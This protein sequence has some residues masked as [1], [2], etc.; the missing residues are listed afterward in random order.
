MGSETHGW[1]TPLSTVLGAVDVSDG[2]LEERLDEL[3]CVAAQIFD[4]AGAGLMVLDADSHLRLI[5]ASDEAGQALER[6]QLEACAGPGIEA[7]RTREIVEVA[8]FSGD[9]RW[10]Q[11]QRAVTSFGIR[12]VLSAPIWLRDRAA[13]NLNLFDSRP[14]PW[15]STDRERAAAF[16]DV[17]GGM[18]LLAVRAHHQAS[19]LHRLRTRL[20]DGP[21]QPEDKP[22]VA[23]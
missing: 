13:G 3:V 9:N 17:A 5:G 11:V 22:G 21:D 1:L 2:E 7:T 14:R 6:S 8:D 18:L 19:L 20:G 23:A 10:P 15:T 16:A 4:V 12:S